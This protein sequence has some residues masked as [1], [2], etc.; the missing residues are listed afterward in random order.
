MQPRRECRFA[1]ER[2]ESL[3]RLHEDVLRELRGA[4]SVS[5][6]AESEGEDPA[7]VIAIELL[8]GRDVSG[9][10]ARHAPRLVIPVRQWHLDD[11]TPGIHEVRQHTEDRMPVRGGALERVTNSAWR[12]TS[13]ED[14]AVNRQSSR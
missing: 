2:R 13:G 9:A 14:T 7:D 12:G 4:G 8:E 3:P 6:K 1:S 10:R 11:G 5:R